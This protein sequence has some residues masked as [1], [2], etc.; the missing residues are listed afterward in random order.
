MKLK[1]FCTKKEANKM[2]QATYGMGEKICKF[3]I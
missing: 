3:Y 2:K 1:N